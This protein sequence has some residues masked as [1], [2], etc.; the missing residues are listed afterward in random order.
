MVAWLNE[1]DTGIVA[2]CLGVSH[3]PAAEQR[4]EVRRFIDRVIKRLRRL[5]ED[6]D[7][8]LASTK[9]K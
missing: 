9:K 2:V 5:F 1:D 7:A 4:R 3:L 8:K 6:A